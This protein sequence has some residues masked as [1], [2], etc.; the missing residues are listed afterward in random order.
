MIEG[1]FVSPSS[2]PYEIVDRCD[3]RYLNHS[4]QP[5]ID[6]LKEPFYVCLH[7]NT[8]FYS[9]LILPTKFDYDHQA[10]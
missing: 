9:P 7:N 2:L 1:L 8:L 3:A 5:I 6:P 4:Y 10:L